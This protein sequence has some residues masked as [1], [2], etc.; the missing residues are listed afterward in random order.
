MPSSNKSNQEVKKSNQTLSAP[1]NNG[2]TISPREIE[3]LLVIAE[4]NHL[5]EFKMAKEELLEWTKEILRLAP[6]TPITQLRYVM[7]CF[8]TGKIEW[9]RY[10]G[11]QN[12]FRGLRET[13]WDG[14]RWTIARNVW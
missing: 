5:L 10:D 12:F 8:K 11:I 2:L 1:S 14:F 3:Y 6:D 13:R 9:V 7:D 4:T